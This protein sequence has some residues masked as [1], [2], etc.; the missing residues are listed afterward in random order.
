MTFVGQPCPVP[1]IDDE[2]GADSTHP[3]D[4]APSRLLIIV[5]RRSLVRGL[6]AAWAASFNPRM[7]VASVADAEAEL[8]PSAVAQASLVLIGARLGVLG[9]AWF[10]RQV[11]WL[12]AR[13][14]DLPLAAV[15]DP[16]D[17]DAAIAGGR[18]GPPVLQGCIPTVS[19]MEVAAAALQLVAAGGVYLPQRTGE[20]WAA[21]QL[22]PPSP[23]H[24]ASVA[25]LDARLTPRERSVLSLLEQGLAN[26]VIAYQL[27]MSQSTVKAHVHSVISKLNVRNRT[28]AAMRSLRSAPLQGESAPLVA[29]V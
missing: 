4:A 3:S 9:D 23:A 19:S 6:L 7:E 28:E 25:A 20:R 13:R 21:E 11:T 1:L 16:A 22:P 15:V 14:A 10:G 5:E 2:L 27:G 18:E 26:K 24:H 12:R 17:V 29:R 8:S